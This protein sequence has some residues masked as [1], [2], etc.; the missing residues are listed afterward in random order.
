MSAQGQ[1]PGENGSGH[2]IPS[3][4]FFSVAGGQAEATIVSQ[5]GTLFHINAHFKY[6]TSE[7]HHYTRQHFE[8]MLKVLSWTP[9]DINA[10]LMISWIKA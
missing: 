7:K 2:T 4:P 3:P 10:C 5:E 6:P 8:H 9:M 1:A